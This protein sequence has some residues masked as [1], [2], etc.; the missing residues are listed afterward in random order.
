DFQSACWRGHGDGA[1]HQV[2]G[3]DQLLQATAHARHLINSEIP[4]EVKQLGALAGPKC[5]GTRFSPRASR[6]QQATFS[7]SPGRPNQSLVSGWGNVP[8]WANGREGE[9]LR[10]DTSRTANRVCNRVHCLSSAPTI[11]M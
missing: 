5:A 11:Y 8:R 9:T 1:I 2:R 3:L 6:G 7:P 10:R 4:C